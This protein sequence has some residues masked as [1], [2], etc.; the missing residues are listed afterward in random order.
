MDDPERHGMIH[1]TPWQTDFRRTVD[2]LPLIEC[3][4]MK[5]CAECAVESASQSTTRVTESVSRFL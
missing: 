1:G 5:R 2:P 3:A 4:A